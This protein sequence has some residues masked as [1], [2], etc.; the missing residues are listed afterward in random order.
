MSDGQSQ[1]YRDT[2]CSRGKHFFPSEDSEICTN[3]GYRRQGVTKAEDKSLAELRWRDLVDKT[4][5]A[6]MGKEILTECLGVADLLIEK[7]R[8]YGNS[9][10]NPARIFSKASPVEQIRVRIDDK[11]SRLR[12]AQGDEDEDVVMDLL[13]YLILYRIAKKNQDFHQG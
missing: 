4:E 7:N 10:L 9:A 5:S 12:S 3:C 2:E 1:G 6:P 8:K 13:G 11:L